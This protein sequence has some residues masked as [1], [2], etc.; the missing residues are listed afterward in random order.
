MTAMASSRHVSVVLCHVHCRQFAASSNWFTAVW[1]KQLLFCCKI[2]KYKTLI[3]CPHYIV[4][5]QPKTGIPVDFVEYQLVK[6][7]KSALCICTRPCLDYDHSW[8]KRGK[9]VKVFDSG[10]KGPQ[11]NSQ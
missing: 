11:F 1:G 7:C 4:L 10:V 3:L 5:V 2:A 6:Q 8:Q 9:V